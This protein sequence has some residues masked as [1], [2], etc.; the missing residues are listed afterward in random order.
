MT[1]LIPKFKQPATGAVNRPINEK[2]NEIPSLS[3]FD[4]NAN[5][6]T[7]AL[8]LTQP[9][10]HAV[11]P[12]SVVRTLSSKLKDMASILDF[13]GVADGA[14]STGTGTDNTAAFQL[15]IATLGTSG[16]C[17]PGWLGSAPAL[18]APAAALAAFCW[19]RCTDSTARLVRARASW[20]LARAA[21]AWEIGRASCR[22]RVF[23]P[24]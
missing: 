20:A 22:E 1:T 8:T 7:Y 5:F 24:V 15:A 16:S 6:Q 19:A 2:L 12:E 18:L 17:W 3:D 9:V 13:G 14:S 23:N 11:K 4:S 10:D 21:A